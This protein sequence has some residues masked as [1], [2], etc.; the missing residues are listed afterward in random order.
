MK[1]W[2]SCIAALGV[3]VCGAIA[4]GQQNSATEK[5]EAAKEKSPVANCPV[6]NTET[7]NLAI[8]LPT[9]EGPVFFCCTDCM[10]KYKSD[11]GKYIDKVAAQRKILAQRPKVQVM[12]PACKEPV[13]ANVSMEVSGQKVFF[14]SPECMAKYKAEPA[15][16]AEGLANSYTYQTKCPVMG[17]DIDPKSFATLANGNRIYFCCKGCDKK[18]FDDPGKYTANL[19]KQ[20]MNYR[21]K[22]LVKSP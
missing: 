21:P 18:L 20:G 13:D 14:S 12:C 15:K 5:K 3:I 17:E 1:Y 4:V 9:P 10:P 8:S 22:E 6:M 11:P 2:K 16:Y 7:A 19:A